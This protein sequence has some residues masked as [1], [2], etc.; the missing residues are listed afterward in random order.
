MANTSHF[1]FVNSLSISG[2]V[3]DLIPGHF[4]K[5]IQ[6]QEFQFHKVIP[7]VIIHKQLY[8]KA[9]TPQNNKK[10]YRTNL[11]TFTTNVYVKFYFEESVI[12]KYYDLKIN[13]NQEFKIIVILV[14]C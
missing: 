2:Q 14:L 12:C 7:E 6:K 3:N 1:N 8:S 9:F 4:Q 10:I 11:V 5:D 13:W